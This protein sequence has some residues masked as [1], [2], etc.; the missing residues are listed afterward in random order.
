MPLTLADHFALIRAETADLDAHPLSARQTKL[1]LT[2]LDKFADRV[3][4]A[5]RDTAPEKLAPAADIIAWRDALRARCPALASI[6]DACAV[7][8]AAE[9]VTAAVE[10][11]LADYPRLSTADFMV[12]L[13][14]GHT[15]QRVLLT[16]PG[17]T[18]RPARDVIGE[19][20]AWWEASG[21]VEG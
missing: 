15:V 10:V 4:L 16:A 6:F 11:P 7:P 8:P 2:L 9:L 19:A 3:Y 1:V 12:S 20:L 21:L 18:T 5:R 17:G 13:Y 14:N